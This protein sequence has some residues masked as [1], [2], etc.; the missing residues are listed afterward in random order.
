MADTAKTPEAYGNFE[1]LTKKLLGVPKKE[2]DK[3]LKKYESNK[4]RRKAK[5]D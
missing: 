1:S 2:L 3:R 4:A 5:H